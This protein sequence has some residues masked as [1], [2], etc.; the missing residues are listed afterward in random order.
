MNTTPTGDDIPDDPHLADDIGVPD[1]PARDMATAPD[2]IGLS[3]AGQRAFGVS[4]VDAAGASGQDLTG[5]QSD[6][7]DP[8]RPA[9]TG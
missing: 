2:P 6:L 8:H 9:G 3:N 4:D 7:D 1:T 5:D